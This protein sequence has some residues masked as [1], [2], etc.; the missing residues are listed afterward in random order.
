MEE[1]FYALPEKATPHNMRLDGGQ[2]DNKEKN[3]MH[4]PESLLYSPCPR[5]GVGL[6][7]SLICNPI[8]NSLPYHTSSNCQCGRRISSFSRA[9]YDFLTCFIV[10]KYDTSCKALYTSGPNVRIPSSSLTSR[11]IDALRNTV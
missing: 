5:L 6:W 9:Q 1:I 10:W 2:N 3:N 11:S 7:V 8:L 4:R